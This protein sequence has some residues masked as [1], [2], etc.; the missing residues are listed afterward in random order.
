M[1]K[2]PATTIKIDEIRNIFKESCG[3]SGESFSE[4]QFQGFQKFLEIDL[5]DW[6]KGNIKQFYS[7]KI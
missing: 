4:A 2:Q 6:V 7:T 3:K 1:N 5:Y